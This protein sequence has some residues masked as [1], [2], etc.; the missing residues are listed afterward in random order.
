M[1]EQDFQ[2]DL[3][4]DGEIWMGMIKSRN[5]SAHTYNKETADEI[6]NLILDRYFALFTQFERK[7]TELA[8]VV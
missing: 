7:M 2:Y 6:V 1:S 5:Q 8:D 3:I 4:D